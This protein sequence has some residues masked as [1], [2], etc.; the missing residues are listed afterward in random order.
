MSTPI[1]TAVI[2]MSVLF[3]ALLGLI[4]SM[5]R[6]KKK[7]TG[8]LHVIGSLAR[9]EMELRPEGSVIVGGELWRARLSNESG[10][11]ERG[12]HARVVGA[13]GHL[14]EVERAV[15]TDE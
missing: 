13:N 6:H 2:L 3:I 11:L 9:V 12:S 7:S 1:V 4:V 14:L 10:T 15:T 8:A 5:S